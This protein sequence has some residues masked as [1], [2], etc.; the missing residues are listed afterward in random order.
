MDFE[1][2]AI[3][4]QGE[5]HIGS[6]EAVD[7]LT[8]QKKLLTDGLQPIELTELSTNAGWRSLF[9]G[10]VGLNELEFFTSQLALLLESGVRVDKGID[11]I[12]QSNA[13]PALTKLLSKISAM[14]KKGTS[15]SEAFAEF[16]ELLV[17]SI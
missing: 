17:L 16:P 4:Q 13:Q 3:D 14:L 2:K 7:K 1:Y 10:T 8:A 6:I 5:R 15:L 12:M 11:I 9:S